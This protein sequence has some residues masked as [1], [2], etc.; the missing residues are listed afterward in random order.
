M[1]FDSELPDGELGGV[2]ASSADGGL[3][4][5]NTLRSRLARAMPEGFATL[6]LRTAR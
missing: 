3:V 2:E 6:A 4:L 5:R 1:L